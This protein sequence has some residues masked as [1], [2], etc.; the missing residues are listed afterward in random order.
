MAAEISRLPAT[1]SLAETPEKTRRRLGRLKVYR[2]R[3][4]QP[5]RQR[6]GDRGCNSNKEHAW[7]VTALCALFAVLRS[8]GSPPRCFTSPKYIWLYLHRHT[9]SSQ[10]IYFSF[11]DNLIPHCCIS[12]K[13]NNK[14]CSD[15]HASPALLWRGGGRKT[16]YSLHA[17]ARHYSDFAITYGYFVVYLLNSSAQH[18]QKWQACTMRARARFRNNVAM[19]ID[20]GLRT[21]KVLV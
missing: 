5:S 20:E 21:A 18:T 10:L 12:K 6:Q 1:G 4:K 9:F 13:N 14:L 16:W 11:P 15:I 8:E 19:S 2:Q 3:Q 17:H 7:L